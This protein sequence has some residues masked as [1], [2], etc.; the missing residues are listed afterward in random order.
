MY[1]LRMLLGGKCAWCKCSVL[2]ALEVDHIFN[3]GVKDENR[4]RK[5]VFRNN[6]EK[7]LYNMQSLCGICHRLKTNYVFMMKNVHILVRMQDVWKANGMRYF[8][9]EEK[10]LINYDIP[11]R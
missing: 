9:K 4:T 2:N 7:T 1:E 3:D 8:G 10:H 5:Y 11:R 6:P